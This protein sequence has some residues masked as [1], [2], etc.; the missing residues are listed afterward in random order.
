[1]MENELFRYDTM[2]LIWAKLETYRK[3]RIKQAEIIEL[4]QKIK[5]KENKTWLTANFKE[6]GCTTD[7]LRGAYVKDTVKEDTNKLDWL[8]FDLDKFYDDLHLINDL[9]EVKRG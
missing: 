4:E 8:K 7:K 3:I 1:M 6:A 5:E 9:L 2:Q